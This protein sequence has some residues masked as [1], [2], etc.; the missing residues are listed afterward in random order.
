M[1]G[2]YGLKGAGIGIRF[3]ALFI[4]G[5]IFLPVSYILAA[6]TGNAGHH[7]Y[8]L[9]GMGV[10][11]STLLGF[12][13]YVY[14]EGKMGATPGKMVMGLKV[15]KVDGSSCDV[16]AAAIRSLLRVV[17]ALPFA[18]LIGVIS[19]WVSDL[20]QRIGDRAAG[21]LVVKSKDLM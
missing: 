11:L 1:T 14:F 21:T 4:D 19:I 7:G 3:V 8:A 12:A 18:Y 16:Q 10:L 2:Q 20:N 15:I 5:L 13:Y 6:F 9:G 17:D